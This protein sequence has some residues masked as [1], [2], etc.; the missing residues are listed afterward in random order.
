MYEMIYRIICQVYRDAMR[1]ILF[2]AVDNPD[3]AW[4]DILMRMIDG[5]FNYR[6]D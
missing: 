4:D 2:K 1:P 6:G 5:M 3:E